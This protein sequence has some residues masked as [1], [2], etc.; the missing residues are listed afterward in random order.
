MKG[1]V[2]KIVGGQEIVD[3]IWVP[4]TYVY[5]EHSSQYKETYLS[6]SSEGKVSWSRRVQLVFTAVS[7][8]INI[9]III[10]FYVTAWTDLQSLSF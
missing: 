1:T 7:R 4:D 6:I 3:R 10:I 9:T 5:N 8:I 2:E